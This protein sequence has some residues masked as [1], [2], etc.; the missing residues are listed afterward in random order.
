MAE[1]ID[2]KNDFDLGS[3]FILDVAKMLS[4]LLNDDYR[5]VIKY[6]GDDYNFPNDNKKNIIFSTSRESHQF[7]KYYKDK[8]VSLF[9]HNYAPLDNWGYPVEDD[10]IIPMPL[11]P[12]VNDINE[13]IPNIKPFHERE[14]DFCFMG[15]IPHTG[16]RDKFKRCLDKMIQETGNKFKYFVKYT[17]GFNTG[18]DHHQYIQILNNSKVCLCP[19][20][21]T[22]NES[23]RF[24]EAI[25]LGTVPMVET[26]PKFWYYELAPVF[27][28]RWESLDKYLSNTLNFLNSSEGCNALNKVI[29]YSSKVINPKHLA[30]FFKKLIKERI[31]N[32]LESNKL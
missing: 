1:L 32:E 20:G 23:F 4:L 16:T 13:K 28:T 25:K 9:F 14:Y 7:P 19:Q 22:S 15:Q 6:D 2:I 18:L 12:F 10:L 5:V 24:F 31:E 11:G 30:L 26:L 17:D 21:A 8:R 3:K 29:D 27:F